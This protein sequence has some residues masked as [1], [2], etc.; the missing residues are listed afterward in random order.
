MA[1]LIVFDG[2]ERSSSRIYLQD[3]ISNTFMTIILRILLPQTLS[4]RLGRC[5]KLHLRFT[6]VAD[7]G[8]HIK[9][10]YGSIDSFVFQVKT[11][12]MV[13][14]VSLHRIKVDPHTSVME[15]ETVPPLP[16]SDEIHHSI[17][18]AD[19]M[20]EVWD[21]RI[22]VTDVLKNLARHPL[23][24]ITRWNWKAASLGAILRASFY[25]TV[26]QASR[27]SWLVTLTAVAVEL[28]FRFLTTG[29]AGAVVQSFRRATPIWQANIIVSLL[30]PAFSHTVEFVT[31]WAQERYFFD[32][33][34][35]SADGVARSRAFA[36]SVLFSV[37]SVLFNLFAMRHG[38]LLV[39]AGDETRSFTEDLKRIPRMV[40]EF[41]AYL[42]VLMATY[43]ERGKLLYAFGTLFTF[44]LI[45]GTILGTFRQKWQ[46]AWTTTLGAWAFLLCATLLTLAIRFVMRKN[47]K[48]YQKRY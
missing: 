47:G 43:L 11:R 28:V 45:V 21:E 32:L 1:P 36:I 7:S 19:D 48:T 41:T 25:Y 17:A 8:G 46:W 22:Y 13:R 30:L 5:V 31:H 12:L 42:P 9:N 26:Y 2:S 10:A 14:S 27:E 15:R 16:M 3:T 20:E 37:I 6:T 44:G 40:G 39:G 34:A 38:V 18:D 29:M 24:L 4:G 33:F 35:A 23:Q